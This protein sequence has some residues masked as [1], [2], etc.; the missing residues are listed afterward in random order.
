MVDVYVGGGIDPD[1]GSP[2]FRAGARYVFFPITYGNGT[3]VPAFADLHA[4]THNGDVSVHVSVGFEWEMFG[5]LGQPQPDLDT[6][7]LTS[8]AR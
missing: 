1:W 4:A 3:A 8:G 2:V 6:I 5:F 7:L